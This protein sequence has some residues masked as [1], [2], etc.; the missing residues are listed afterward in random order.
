MS[1]EFSPEMFAAPI[2]IMHYF[3]PKNPALYHRSDSGDLDLD[4]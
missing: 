1:R 2:P 3:V 4:T